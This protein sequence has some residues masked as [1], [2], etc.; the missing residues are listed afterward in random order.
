MIIA[1]L[2]FAASFWVELQGYPRVKR[3]EAEA[4]FVSAFS[5]AINPLFFVGLPLGLYWLSRCGEL[6]SWLIRLGFR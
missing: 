6:K 1:L 4:W 2:G 3:D 5:G